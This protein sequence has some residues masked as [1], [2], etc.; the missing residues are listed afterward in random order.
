MEMVNLIFG[1][2]SPAS[3]GIVTPEIR[4][5]LAGGSPIVFSVYLHIDSMII[6]GLTAIVISILH[7]FSIPAIRLL[8]MD[9]ALIFRLVVA[10]PH[11]CARVR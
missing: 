8:L 4:H 6:L 2:S 11:L 10:A 5:Q 3:F 9:I 7:Q 1:Y